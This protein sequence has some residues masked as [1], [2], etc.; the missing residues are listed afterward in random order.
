[1]SHADG[2]GCGHWSFPYFHTVTNSHLH[3]MIGEH[4]TPLHVS[5]KGRIW[6]KLRFLGFHLRITANLITLLVLTYKENEV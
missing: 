6:G 5:Q 3:S 1:M 4:A 2:S